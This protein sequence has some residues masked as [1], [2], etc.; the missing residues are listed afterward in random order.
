VIIASLS[1]SSEVS[2]QV[3]RALDGDVS[4]LGGAGKCRERVSSR[5]VTTPP[6]YCE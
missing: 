3:H 5:E 2:E 6:I 4:E 1:S